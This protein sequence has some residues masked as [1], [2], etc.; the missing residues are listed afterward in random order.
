MLKTFK[1][2][3]IAFVCGLAFLCTRVAIYYFSQEQVIFPVPDIE[4]GSV[5]DTDFEPVSISTKD[6]ETLF[7]LH[8]ASE[9]YESTILIFHGNAGAAI[10]QRDRGRLFVNA[11]YGVLLVEYRGYPG[12]TGIP[13]ELGF[14]E[15]AQ[16]A[17]DYVVGQK[18]QP[19]GLYAHSLGTSVAIRLASKRD[20]F[21]VVLESP[22]DSILA[23][24]QNRFPWLPVSPFLKYKFESYKSFGN[25]KS[26]AL[27]IHGTEDQVIP[28]EHSNKLLEFAPP[29]V[30]FISIKGAGHNNLS[31]FGS[32]NL[33]LKFFNEKLP[34]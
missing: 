15:D 2:L 6:G 33:A 28:I 8:H 22:F 5:E 21:S 24:A 29:G 14:Y 31:D 12:S 4:V 18:Q 34:N 25:V 23:V 19:I 17:Y 13:S 30:K 20:V 10:N 9:D 1:F 7:A 3:M 16:A 11:G 26:P 32:E 27:I